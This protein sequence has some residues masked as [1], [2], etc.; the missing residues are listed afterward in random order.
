MPQS[1]YERKLEEIDQLLNDPNVPLHPARIWF[2]LTEVAEHGPIAD[3]CRSYGN[4][5]SDG[6][7]PGAPTSPR[8]P[9]TMRGI[10]DER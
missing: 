2:L 4:L 5:N 1:E 8:L 3:K 6:K 9:T 10:F 7:L